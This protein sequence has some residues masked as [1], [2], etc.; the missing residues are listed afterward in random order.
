MASS[1]GGHQEGGWQIESKEPTPCVLTHTSGVGAHRRVSRFT[2]PRHVISA[3]RGRAARSAVATA[4]SPHQSLL[5]S[6]IRHLYGSNRFCVSHAMDL[7]VTCRN[8]DPHKRIISPTLDLRKQQ[9]ARAKV[10]LDWSGQ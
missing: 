6:V 10:M 5:N 2:V 7:G 8:L 9:Q 4:R 1:D 3:G